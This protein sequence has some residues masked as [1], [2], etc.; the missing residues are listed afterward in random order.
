MNNSEYKFVR[1]SSNNLADLLIL[2]KDAYGREDSIERLKKKYNT[3][4]W[5]AQFI[6]YIAYSRE[7]EEVAAYYGVFPISF[8][9]EGKVVL[10]A[11]SGDTM[12]HSNHRR[13]GL[14]VQLAEKTYLLAKEKGV[15][16]IFGF[17]NDNSFPGF[18]NKLGWQFEKKMKNYNFI[19]PTLP[20]DLVM[21]KIGEGS[22]SKTRDKYCLKVLSYFMS[23]NIP[24][25]FSTNENYNSCVLIKDLNYFRYKHSN[26]HFVYSYNNK[27]KLWIKYD[28]SLVIGDISFDNENCSESIKTKIIKEALYRIK[29]MASFCGI[30]RIKMYVSPNSNIDKIFKNIKHRDGL[31]I[32]YLDFGS[33]IPLG[34]FSFTYSDFDTF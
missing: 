1:L 23:G 25:V 26:N 12:T 22:L 28:G 21:K 33:N 17:P 19:V 29:L 34:K 31:N 30:I 8:K 2:I 11:Q 27:V 3:K 14:F 18:K 15:K 4:I 9:H 10:A 24:F 13:R 6:G 32:G 5:G 20:V 7:S 16:F